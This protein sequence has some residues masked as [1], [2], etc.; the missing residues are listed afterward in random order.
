VLL[1]SACRAS[2]EQDIHS[3]EGVCVA[4]LRLLSMTRD[5]NRR[6]KSFRLKVISHCVTREVHTPNKHCGT[7]RVEKDPYLYGNCTDRQL[8]VRLIGSN[9][10]I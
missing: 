9:W 8:A 4:K 3:Q 10:D 6:A 1:T 7:D 5:Q 2:F